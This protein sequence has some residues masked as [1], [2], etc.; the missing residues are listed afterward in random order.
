MIFHRAV[1][2]G[3]W[4]ALPVSSKLWNFSCGWGNEC[5]LDSLTSPKGWVYTVIFPN[6][7]EHYLC[8]CN[9]T[10]K[11]P[12][13][14]RTDATR[15]GGGRAGGQAERQPV[16]AQPPSSQVFQRNSATTEQQSTA[17]N[18][19]VVILQRPRERKRHLCLLLC[20]CFGLCQS[21]QELVDEDPDYLFPLLSALSLLNYGRFLIQTLSLT[22]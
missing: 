16:S 7:Q 12:W 5:Q 17:K 2:P 22:I 11:F 3:S 10:P 19:W 21:R 8:S 1:P 4:P 6:L 13:N 14:S 15:A 9:F 18:P 20:P